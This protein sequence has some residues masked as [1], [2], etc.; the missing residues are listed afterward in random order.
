MKKESIQESLK[1]ILK[2]GEPLANNLIKKAKKN[3]DESLTSFLD[4]LGENK[5]Q[6]TNEVT[7][8]KPKVFKNENFYK[9]ELPGYFEHECKVSLEDGYYVLRTQKSSFELVGEYADIKMPC[10][11]DESEGLKTLF[12]NGLLF[13]MPATVV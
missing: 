3:I 8:K 1:K 9:I 6:S 12:L 2:H 10:I 4:S 13:V 11:G 5:D 7:I